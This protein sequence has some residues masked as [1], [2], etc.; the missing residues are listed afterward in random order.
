MRELAQI[1]FERAARAAADAEA[2]EEKQV[3]E[4][5]SGEAEEV[6]PHA[7][8]VCVPFAEDWMIESATAELDSRDAG[9]Q[10]QKPPAISPN[11]D[12]ETPIRGQ[13]TYYLMFN[14]PVPVGLTTT[15]ALSFPMR[16]PASFCRAQLCHFI[17]EHEHLVTP[18]ENLEALSS[19][20]SWVR[21]IRSQ[22]IFLCCVER[23]DAG[24]NP[25]MR[26][27]APALQGL[28]EACEDSLAGLFEDP[29]VYSKHSTERRS[30][31]PTSS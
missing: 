8:H 7:E 15:V 1:R 11:F 24:L 25:D 4:E 21:K 23:A 19:S 2:E 29:S 10:M 6:A 12:S 26:I 5:L 28:H 16:R 17:W 30:F 13:R 18:K 27:A 31:K 9:R 3:H 20:S 14:Q 22:G